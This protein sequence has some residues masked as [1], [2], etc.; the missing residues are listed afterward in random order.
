[1]YLIFNCFLLIYLNYWKGLWELFP[2]AT[3]P[4][5]GNMTIVHGYILYI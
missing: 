1:M 3:I 5:I 2:I 4:L